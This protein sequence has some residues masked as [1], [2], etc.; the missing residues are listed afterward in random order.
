M[1]EN[2]TNNGLLPAVKRGKSYTKVED[3]LNCRAFIMASEDAVVG[4]SQKGREF[5]STHHKEYVR[6][7]DQ[8]E[9][10]DQT[11]FDRSSESYRS[12]MGGSPPVYHR[13]TPDSVYTRFKDVIASR[14]MKFIGIEQT[15]DKPSGTTDD[16]Y[17]DLCNA[18]YQRRY[19]SLGNFADFRQ[20]KEY[21]ADSPKFFSYKKMVEDEAA[22][23]KARPKG[24]D[25]TKRKEA[26]LQLAKK[27]LENE[28]A[29]A[30]TEATS[31]QSQVVELISDIGGNMIRQWNQESD[32]RFAEMLPAR[33]KRQWCAEMFEIKMLEAQVKKRKLQEKLQYH[34]TQDSASSTAPSQR[35]GELTN[36]SDES[37]DDSDG[38]DDSVLL[39][40]LGNDG[41]GF[42]PYSST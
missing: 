34:L 1:A 14:T 36:Y 13:R 33:Q 8:Q 22:A 38:D 5:K 25:K 12:S 10:E 30:T 41:G 19:P 23:R 29:T 39:A 2:A 16:E 15:T 31:V 21:L 26:D 37:A 32:V 11:V 40:S 3:L 18:T 28:K 27:V 4:T 35:T 24:R 17:F 20:C 9:K 7:L 6:L 42:L